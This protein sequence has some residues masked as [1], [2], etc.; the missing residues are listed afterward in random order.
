MD[1]IYL[2]AVCG[3]LA[4]ILIGWYIGRRS[5]GKGIF[6][7]LIASDQDTRLW[8]FTMFGLCLGIVTSLGAIGVILAYH[9]IDP[10][11]ISLVSTYNGV[12]LGATVTTS[13][14]YWLGSSAGSKRKDEALA[15]VAQN[16]NQGG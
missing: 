16:T 11:V 1:Y 15:T 7:A 8:I 6:D 14:N 5:A 10:V 12:V 4:L 3:V 13:Y 9:I 2:I